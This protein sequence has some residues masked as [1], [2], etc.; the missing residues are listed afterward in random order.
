MT[1]I[2][3]ETITIDLDQDLEFRMVQSYVDT[4]FT[5][6]SKSVFDDEVASGIDA[7]IAFYDAWRNEQVIIAL[8]WSLD[9]EQL[10][11]KQALS[12]TQSGGYNLDLGT[13]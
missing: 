8:Q 6:Q 3:N 5:P 9:Q 12:D 10:K 4:K 2:K 13:I 1:D 7:R 11:Q